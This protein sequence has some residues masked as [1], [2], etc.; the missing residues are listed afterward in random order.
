MPFEEVTLPCDGLQLSAWFI[1]GKQGADR[2]VVFVAH[3]I[4]ATKQNFLSVA[5][6]IHQWG[7]NVFMLDFR[8][9]GDSAGMLSTLGM[10]EAN[11]VK[12][13]CDWIAQRC[14]GRPIY[15]LGYS[16]GGAAL[17]RACAQYGLCD[18]VILDCTFAR[19]ENSFRHTMGGFYIPRPLVSLGWHAC[20]FW[21]WTFT[22]TDPHDLETEHSIEELRNQTLLLIHGTKDR[23]TPFTDSVRLGEQCNGKAEVWLVEGAGHLQALAN[24][25][26]LDRIRRFLDC[27]DCDAAFTD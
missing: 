24:P 20:R 8:A 6:Q 5:E 27:K 16:M 11:D 1:P 22:G 25:E 7:Y 14:P 15:G 9:H 18:R 21:G 2:T 10:K 12:A 23:T 26:Y 4:G 17:V 3:G 13:G 19:L